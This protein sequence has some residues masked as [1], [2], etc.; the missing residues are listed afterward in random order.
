ME[1]DP[2]G[3]IEWSSQRPEDV[4]SLKRGTTEGGGGRAFGSFLGDIRGLRRVFE[5]VS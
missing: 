1:R 4:I 2:L 3:L 5:V